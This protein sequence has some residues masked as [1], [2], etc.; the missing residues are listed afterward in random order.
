MSSFN[1]T[2]IVEYD[3]DVLSHV[4]SVQVV[5]VL[6][7]TLVLVVNLSEELKELVKVNDLQNVVFL[8]Q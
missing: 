3:I 2:L 7:R 6:H 8:Q 1:H 4:T 5:V